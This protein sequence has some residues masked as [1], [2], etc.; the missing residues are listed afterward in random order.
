MPMMNSTIYSLQADAERRKRSEAETRRRKVIERQDAP[1]AVAGKIAGIR[2]V[3]DKM[4]AEARK[5]DAL[6]RAGKV[7]SIDSWA[8]HVATLD[9]FMDGIHNLKR[10]VKE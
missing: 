1:A 9:A 10:I 7:Y 6:R 8:K 2:P 5:Q 3:L 4:E